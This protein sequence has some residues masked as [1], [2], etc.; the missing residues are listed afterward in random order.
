MNLKK[1][2][3]NEVFL[4]SSSIVL[5]ILLW[6]LFD[7]AS[8]SSF[9]LAA[10]RWIGE[11]C[12]WFYILIMNSCMLVLLFFLHP[13]FKNLLDF[14]EPAEHSL[15]SWL[16]MLFTA[17]IGIGLLYYGMAEPLTHTQNPPNNMMAGSEAAREF[18]LA[19][20]M[21]HYGF[22]VWA[23]YALVGLGLL[24]YEMEYNLPFRISSLL[25]PILETRSLEHGVQPWMSW[26]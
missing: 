24:Y 15:T 8:L 1:L 13:R 26:Q 12:A 25:H 9:A 11:N 21:L 7:L 6:G 5:A 18:G 17:G 19:I 20:T 3:L 16:A 10:N 4:I 23:L 2:Q 22:Q 14:Q